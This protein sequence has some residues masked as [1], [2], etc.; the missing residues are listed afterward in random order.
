MTYTRRDFGKFAV[1]TGAV[2]TL[3]NAKEMFAAASRIPRS[4]AC[5]SA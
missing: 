5:R 4:T 2:A 1:A 3:G